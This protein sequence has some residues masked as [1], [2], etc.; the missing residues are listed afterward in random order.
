MSWFL[1]L[2][3][4]EKEAAFEDS[5]QVYFGI[6]NIN[7]LKTIINTILADPPY[8]QSRL[9]YFNEIQNNPS[10]NE[11]L[12][13]NGRTLISSKKIQD[14]LSLIS[15][16]NPKFRANTSALNNELQNIVALQIEKERS[17]AEQKFSQNRKVTTFRV[18]E[19]THEW[20][21]YALS[22]TSHIL[23]KETGFLFS[24][25]DPN[26]KSYNP[27]RAELQN[28]LGVELRRDR[29]QYYKN[30]KKK[31]TPPG[32]KVYFLSREWVVLGLTPE[33]IPE[34]INIF[35]EMGYDT[36][37]IDLFINNIN[38]EQPSNIKN[39]KFRIKF[40]NV[41]LVSDYHLSV[42]LSQFLTIDAPRDSL[43]NFRDVVNKIFTVEGKKAVFI[44]PSG[45][46]A[47][48]QLSDRR[49]ENIAKKRES[50]IQPSGEY[51]EMS[52]TSYGAKGK[53]LLFLRGNYNSFQ[54]FQKLLA[55]K[56]FDTTDLVNKTLQKGSELRNSGHIKMQRIING[57]L[58][59]YY[60]ARQSG[61]FVKDKN[62][63]YLPNEEKFQAEVLEYTVQ[64]SGQEPYNLYP[65]QG[66][67]VQWLYTRQS[68]LLGD[69]AGAGKTEQ[70]IVAAD[71]RTKEKNFWDPKLATGKVLIFTLAS[72]VEQFAQRI[73]Q[74]LGMPDTDEFLRSPESPVKL[75][76]EDM[77]HP[78][79]KWLILSYGKI[80]TLTQLQQENQMGDTEEADDAIEM[81]DPEMLGTKKQ[82]IMKVK[83]LLRQIRLQNFDVM[84]LDESHMVKNSTS[85][86]S[87][88]IELI[89]NNIPFKWGASATVSA[90]NP[91]DLH[92]QLLAVGNSMGAMPA[93]KFNRQYTGMKS[94]KIQ[95]QEKEY[96]ADP[97]NARDFIKFVRREDSRFDQLD[98]NGQLGLIKQ[99]AEE[100]LRPIVNKQIENVTDLH[101]MLILTDVYR[102][103]TKKQIQPDLPNHNRTENLI[104]TDENFK[105]NLKQ[106]A[107]I[108]LSEMQNNE[109]NKKSTLTELTA[110]RIEMA[111][112]KVPYTTN[113]VMEFIQQGQKVLVFT[114][115]L[116][117]ATLLEK[118]LRALLQPQGM[119]VYMTM[120]EGT[121]TYE[122][123]NMIEKF[124]N[125]NSSVRCF[126]LGVMSSGTG[127]DLPNIVNNVIINDI[128]WT[129]KDA[130]QVEGRAFR[131]N[132]K[133][134]VSTHYIVLDETPDKVIY[135][136]VQKK[137]NIAQRIQ[138]VDAEY[139]EKFRNGEDT[140]P[141]LIKAQKEHWSL[142]LEHLFSEVRVQ[143]FWTTTKTTSPRSRVAY[144]WFQTQLFK[145]CVKKTPWSLAKGVN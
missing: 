113:K 67:G 43:T 7:N 20:T 44:E 22:W 136:T 61:H 110:Y 21:T 15:L 129:P 135:N 142:V 89:G 73:L 51:V 17:R 42:D 96:L 70:L 56:N 79:A 35:Q 116:E 125:P 68:A 130:D 46:S 39:K 23:E 53:G 10:L 86:T 65:L 119:E 98:L 133:S 85:N 118:S 37:V 115:F 31:P 97:S 36:F 122:K 55:I 87:K 144:N 114:C 13:N 26:E 94:Q 18:L 60:I 99:L 95:G 83:E 50:L 90:N 41:S 52:K 138:D 80:N 34:M 120:G 3:E 107:N 5:L 24:G 77:Q 48:A 131:V 140:R 91:S 74:V 84:I 127:L 45:I 124:R 117:S 76:I 123:N 137:R 82:R 29:P 75:N 4:L 134:D 81:V 145:H 57:V 14:M 102:R 63:V 54:D 72:V 33:K 62:G 16:Y 64:K 103:K 1:K 59:G 58:D 112:Q 93:R 32:Q 132:S 28:R 141:E 2:F 47:T 71:M 66:Q 30:G 92:R 143:Y 25:L 12:S 111:V 105:Y 8:D 109:D 40:N 106:A 139:A 38:S 121:G 78:N 126:V 88:N 108:R 19:K 101:A 100:Y 9:Y 11:I 49:K 6:R 128:S 104:P 27:I 69:A